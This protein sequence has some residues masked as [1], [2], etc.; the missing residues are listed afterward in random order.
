MA[1][2]SFLNCPKKDTVIFTM[3]EVSGVEKSKR[4]SCETRR[5]KL[6]RAPFHAGSNRLR[7]SNRILRLFNFRDVWT[8]Q[9]VNGFR[10]EGRDSVAQVPGPSTASDRSFGPCRASILE[11]SPR[12]PCGHFRRRVGPNLNLIEHALFPRPRTFTALVQ[13]LNSA[14]FPHDHHRCDLCVGPESDYTDPAIFPR[15][16]VQTNPCLLN[17][18]LDYVRPPISPFLQYFHQ[19]QDR[20]TV[21]EPVQNVPLPS[22]DLSKSICNSKFVGRFRK[23]LQRLPA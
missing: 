19:V 21:R 2:R 14:N 20:E 10:Y 7:C 22:H 6:N 9:A 15:K 8:R 16:N 1:D 4:P 5:L 3:K 17:G 11:S 18:A 23:R 13:P 12:R